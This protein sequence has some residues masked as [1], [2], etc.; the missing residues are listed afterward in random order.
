MTSIIIF[1]YVKHIYQ[2]PKCF[3]HT[4]SAE[5][6]Q[7]LAISVTLNFAFTD[8]SRKKHFFLDI[9]SFSYVTSTWFFETYVFLLTIP[10][11]DLVMFSCNNYD[12]M[13]LN[14]RITS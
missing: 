9:I 12:Y 1:Y 6:L 7:I 11:H 5:I 13:F 8:P 4:E 2:S 3:S 14:V 10:D